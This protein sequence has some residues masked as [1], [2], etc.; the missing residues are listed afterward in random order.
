MTLDPYNNYEVLASDSDPSTIA[1]NMLSC[2]GRPWTNSLS[3]PG[4]T[5]IPQDLLDPGTEYD[6]ISST[7][8]SPK[9]YYMERKVFDA[10]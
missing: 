3:Y 5:S 4:Y 6:F 7:T 9:V 8:D 10:V 1:D 2:N